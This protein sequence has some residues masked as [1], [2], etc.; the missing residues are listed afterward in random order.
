VI[1]WA[2]ALSVLIENTDVPVA[3][4]ATVA[5]VFATPLKAIVPEEGAHAVEVTVAVKTTPCP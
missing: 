1:V 4:T 2:V 5:G 3:S